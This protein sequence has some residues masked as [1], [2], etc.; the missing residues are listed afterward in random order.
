LI[1][2]MIYDCMIILFFLLSVCEFLITGNALD[3][4]E[5]YFKDIDYNFMVAA[6]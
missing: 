5:A 3:Y 2:A 4:S 1:G 6:I